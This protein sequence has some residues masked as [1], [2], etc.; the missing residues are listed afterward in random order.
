VNI[1]SPLVYVGRIQGKNVVDAAK[2]NGIQHLVFS[3]LRSP[4]EL[5]GL[6]G[7]HH[8]E[9]KKVIYDYIIE[10]GGRI[11][12]V[13]FLKRFYYLWQTVDVLQLFVLFVFVDARTRSS[14]V[15]GLERIT[16]KCRSNSVAIRRTRDT[17]PERCQFRHS[18]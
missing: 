13:S 4:K 2:E 17:L 6:D 8:F 7:C 3:G 12:R 11:S 14:T 16:L 18:L 5:A 10:Q 9:T 1:R 15:A